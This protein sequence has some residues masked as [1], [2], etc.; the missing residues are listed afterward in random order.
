MVFVTLTWISHGFTCIPHPDP[1][2]CLPL[3]PIP[4]FGL[5]EKARVGCF[6][7]TASKHVYYLGWNR[8]PAQAGCMR[9]VLGPGAL[10]GFAFLTG[11]FD[12]NLE[13]RAV[14][15]WGSTSQFFSLCLNFAFYAFS[16]F[17]ESSLSPSSPGSSLW[18]SLEKGSEEASLVGMLIYHF[19]HWVRERYH[20]CA[21]L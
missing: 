2:S 1:P 20:L 6:E 12:L 14:R 16:S 13:L 9:Q 8:S 7:R 5:W 15:G 19:P 11:S 21:I 18:W 4:P 10:G 3:H 17:C